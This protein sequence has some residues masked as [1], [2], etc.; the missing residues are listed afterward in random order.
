MNTFIDIVKLI[1]YLS[2]KLFPINKKLI[3]FE[4]H[5]GLS[6]S[7]NPKYIYEELLQYTSNYVCVWSLQDTN[8]AIKGDAIKVTRFSLKYYFYLATAQ[9]W[10]NNGEFGRKVVRRKGTTY[11]NTQHGTP[12]K[13]MGVDIP[14]LS[15]KKRMFDKSKKWD[16]LISPNAYTTEIWR[17][18]YRF[19]G[20]ILETGYPRNDIFYRDNKIESIRRLKER[21]GLSLNKKVILYAPTYRDSFVRSNGKADTVGFELKPDLNLLHEKLSGEYVLVIRLHHLISQE[22]Y[23]DLEGISQNGDSGFFRD[24]SAAAYDAQELCLVSDILIT[25]YSSIMFDYANLRRPILFYTYDMEDY[26]NDIRGLYLNFNKIAPGP[27]LKNTE[28]L[29]D[30]IIN[31]EILKN[32]YWEKLNAFYNKFCY[33]DEGISAQRIVEKFF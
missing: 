19:S 25:D 23:F 1:F 33:L 26:Q 21:L 14:Y 28:E 30:A 6:Y 29:V 5:R 15:H 3:V 13:K 2:F 12:L 20:E 17:R 10:I 4:S 27:I 11:I 22:N 9:Y 18:A 32:E 7:C 31:I 24:F 16:Y 8:T